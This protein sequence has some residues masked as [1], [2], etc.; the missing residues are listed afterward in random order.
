MG[1]SRRRPRVRPLAS[2]ITVIGA[3]TVG[4]VAIALTSDDAGGP[5]TLRAVARVIDGDTLVLAGT[6]IRLNGIDAPEA[7]QT[8][9]ARDGT[10]WP[11]G[12]VAT[13]ALAK[14]ISS[15]LVGCKTHGHDRY[16]RTLGT[17]YA[18]G[19]NLNALMV[20]RGFARAYTSRSWRY[21]INEWQAWMDG[22]G[23]WAGSSEPPWVFRARRFGS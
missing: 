15:R 19:N 10:S 4:A 1:F 18:G 6:T 2:L 12:A 20:R 13:A 22:A 14:L 21:T 17:C 9:G 3:T 23:I 7:A 5:P 11:C 8:C 16:G